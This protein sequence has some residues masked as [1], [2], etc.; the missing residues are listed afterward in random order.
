MKKGQ[1]IFRVH[2]KLTSYDRYILLGLVSTEPD[3]KLSLAIN[4]KLMLSLKNNTPLEFVDEKGNHLSFSRFS[5]LNGATEIT[6]SLISNRSDKNI[7]LKKYKNIDYFLQVHD[8][9]GDKDISQ[10]IDNLREIDSITAVFNIDISEIK[11]KNI[12]YLI[13]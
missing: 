8:N 12:H 5:D 2:L 9:E 13:P 10:F 1:K 6:Y 7:L 3:Y 4:K 11:D